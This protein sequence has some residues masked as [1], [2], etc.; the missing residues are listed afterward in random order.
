MYK[1]K[2]EY[3]L[4]ITTIDEQHAKLFELTE[5]AYELLK[6]E[7]LLYKNDKLS[8]IMKGIKEYIEIHFAEEE[9]YLQQIGY[10]DFNAHKELHEI[11]RNKVN[12]FARNAMELSLM[13][14]DDII[15]DLLDYL[16]MWL[17]KHI[18]E[19]DRKY[20]K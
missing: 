1:M 9:G 17:E 13:T 12:D 18:C 10:A 3:L 8:E 16:V 2:N 14:Q 7:N 15:L 5:E 11:F 6:N 19:E 4:G 20:V